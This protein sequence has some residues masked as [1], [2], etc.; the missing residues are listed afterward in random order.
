MRFYVCVLGSIE[1]E[2]GS[3]SAGDGS[4][5]IFQRDFSSDRSVKD[6]KQTALWLLSQILLLLSALRS[7]NCQVLFL[8]CYCCEGT[9]GSQKTY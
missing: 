7:L 4:W 6:K 5:S 1:W 2:A 8:P 3:V 9:L